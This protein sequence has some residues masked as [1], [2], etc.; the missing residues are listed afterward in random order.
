MINILFS[1][2]LREFMLYKTDASAMFMYSILF[3]KLVN[4][5]FCFS[6]F[7]FFFYMYFALSSDSLFRTGGLHITHL[8]C[9]WCVLKLPGRYFSSFKLWSL[10][11]NIARSRGLTFN[12]LNNS[13]DNLIQSIYLNLNNM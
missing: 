6:L 7:C 9:S 13:T 11:Y 8:T 3:I 2:L 1:Q 12:L 5:L 10:I 4:S